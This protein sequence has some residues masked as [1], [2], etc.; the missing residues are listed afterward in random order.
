[1]VTTYK[2]RIVADLIDL[3]AEVVQEIK[4][5]LTFDG[6]LS[7]A[8]SKKYEAIRIIGKPGAA[9]NFLCTALGML[10]TAAPKFLR[11]GG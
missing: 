7:L 6:Y 1:M 9:K 3:E 11:G 4:R 10:Y 2:L 5:K 8:A